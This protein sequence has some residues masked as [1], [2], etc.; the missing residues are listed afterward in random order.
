MK[1]TNPELAQHIDPSR[2]VAAHLRSPA[3]PSARRAARP[4]SPH[5]S[6]RLLLGLA[7]AAQALGAS[8]CSTLSPEGTASAAVSTASASPAASSPAAAAPASAGSSVSTGA[9]PAAATASLIERG[10]HLV[11]TSA[12]H[13]CHTPMKLGDSGPEPDMSRMLSGHPE[14]AELPPAPQ[15]AP[16]WVVASS[17]TNTAWAGPWG[18]SF[19][20][21]LTPDRETGLGSWT[22][23][24]FTAALKTGRHEGRGRPILPPMPIPAYQ[25]F[26]EQ[27][28]EAI[29]AYL[30]T[31][32]AVKNR[33]P[34][35][36][37]PAG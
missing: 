24:T 8:A 12:C 3:R 31:I 32:P 7:I 28:L 17:A 9:T 2:P 5:G 14:S 1:H 6:G 10:E 37:P 29:F 25:N 13:D 4:A 27:E 30:Q 19:T 22:K 15:A 36:L 21:N 33:V 35:P 34:A 26:T 20:A 23:E 16:P 11:L 18:T